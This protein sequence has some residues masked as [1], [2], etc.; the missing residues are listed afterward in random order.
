MFQVAPYP[1]RPLTAFA[2]RELWGV[3]EILWGDHFSAIRYDRSARIVGFEPKM[4]WQTDVQRRNGSNLYRF[5]TPVPGGDPIVEWL[6]QDDVI[7]IAGI[8]FDGIRGMSVIRANAHNS[9]ALSAMLIEQIGRVHENAAR[10]S[11]MADSAGGRKRKGVPDVSR[12]NSPRTTPA[13]RTPARSF[14]ASPD[15][16]S[17]RSRCR[18][19]I[20]TP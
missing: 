4:P 6:D 9:V 17:N 10:P 20:C 1:G 2:W 18:P 5:E 16:T 3:N 12:R 14:S 7:H 13:A 8:G 15:G 19:R 11:G